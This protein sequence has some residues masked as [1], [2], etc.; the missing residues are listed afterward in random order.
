[1]VF[2]LSVFLSEVGRGVAAGV[3]EGVGNGVVAVDV[4]AEAESILEIEL[5]GKQSMLRSLT[6]SKVGLRFNAG[7]AGC[8]VASPLSEA[9]KGVGA[10][11]LECLR[12]GA[13]DLE[14]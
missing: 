11:V 14:D 8:A 7:G 6:G 5:R 2:S 13:V 1:M 12:L 10:G 4:G 9:V 3:A